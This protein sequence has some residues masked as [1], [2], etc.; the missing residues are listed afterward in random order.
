VKK[1]LW[2]R[3]RPI[4]TYSLLAALLYFALRNAP[5]TEIWEA[6]RMLQAWQ[7]SLLFVLNVLIYALISLRWWLIVRAE[8]RDVSFFRSTA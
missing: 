4:L 6:L 2:Q 3:A 5:L 7:I 8:K 1:T